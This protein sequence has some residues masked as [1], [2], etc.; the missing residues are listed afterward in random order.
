MILAPLL[1]INNA[2]ANTMTFTPPNKIGYV[3]VIIEPAPYIKMIDATAKDSYVIDYCIQWG[4]FNSCKK[5][6]KSSEHAFIL[7]FNHTKLDSHKVT[8]T[9]TQGKVVGIEQG[10]SPEI[11]YSTTLICTGARFATC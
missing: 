6:S 4:S 7:G 10:N 1:L 11:P 3:W 9:T 5:I 8:V 2:F